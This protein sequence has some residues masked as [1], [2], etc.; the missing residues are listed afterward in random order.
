MEDSV[1]RKNLSVLPLLGFSMLIA[2]L[3]AIAQTQQ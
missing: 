1:M 3:Q 2:P